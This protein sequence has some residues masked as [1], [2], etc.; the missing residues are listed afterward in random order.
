[1]NALRATAWAYGATI[2]IHLV[3]HLLRG[4]GASPGGVIALGTLA[5]AAQ[6]LAIVAVLRGHR[7]GALLAFAVGLP[8]ALGVVAVHLLPTWSALSDSYAGGAP[9]TTWF[10]WTTA[11]AEVLAAAAF[12]A[13][14][15][16]RMRRGPAPHDREPGLGTV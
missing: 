13:A 3:D 16:A 4:T 10:S 14:G 12:A 6:V 1:M 11:I 5:L 9:G 15:W 7:Y 8:D 2:A